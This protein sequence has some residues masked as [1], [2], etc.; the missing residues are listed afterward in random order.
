M[1]LSF[2]LTGFPLVVMAIVA[3][4]GG[5]ALNGSALVS[6]NNG[7]NSG[8]TTTD[9]SSYSLTTANAA[10]SPTP[11][12]TSQPTSV[13]ITCVSPSKYI[14]Q[15]GNNYSGCVIFNGCPSYALLPLACYQTSSSTPF[16]TILFKGV[17]AVFGTGGT[18][19]NQ[20]SLFGSNAFSV[21]ND[22]TLII[23]ALIALAVLGSVS[24]FG[25]QFFTI[26]S[27]HMVFEFGGLS[28]LW[29]ILTVASGFGASDSFWSQL[30][31]ASGVLLL[32]TMSFIFLSLIYTVG[33]LR[34]ISRGG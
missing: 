27:A 5:S 11:C 14:D 33:I 32:G 25:T 7:V 29:I 22:Y 18:V 4:V 19:Q 24:V 9:C 8:A 30:N 15:Y 23:V 26:E 31:Q 28:I 6:I 2:G 1:G 17:T 20:P 34:T 21:A 16:N 12:L 10:G 13:T 3:I